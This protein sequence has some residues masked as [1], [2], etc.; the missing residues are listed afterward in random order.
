MNNLPTTTKGVSSISCQCGQESCTGLT[1]LICF[2]TVGSGSCRVQDPGNYGFN[3]MYTGR[4]LDPS[5]AGRNL[6][7]D[8][9]LCEEAATSIGLTDQTATVVTL[10]DT[11]PGCSF[12]SDGLVFNSYYS[13]PASCSTSSDYC[14]CISAPVCNNNDGLVLNPGKGF[15]VVRKKSVYH[16]FSWQFKI[17]NTRI[18]GNFW[19]TITIST[20]CNHL[21]F[22]G[23]WLSFV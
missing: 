7:Q 19:H 3:R 14:I 21:P 15:V 17:Q 9:A 22:V 11:P 8:Q 20:C 10:L 18:G 1:G 4:C 5:V 13:S 2:A 12:S 23:V 6:I 16:F